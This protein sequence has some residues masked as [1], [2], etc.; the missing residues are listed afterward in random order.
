MV[1]FPC[2]RLN[3]L[4]MYLL[5]NI[6]IE[7]LLCS[8]LWAKNCGY[9][10]KPKSHGNYILVCVDGRWGGAGVNQ[11]FTQVIVKCF[12]FALKLIKKTGYLFILL[13]QQ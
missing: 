4:A 5:Q 10:G 3:I 9:N 7:D 8:R 6:L 13:Q 12:F 2:G 1:H 11:I